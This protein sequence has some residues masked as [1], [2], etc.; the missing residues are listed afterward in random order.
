MK[1]QEGPFLVILCNVF[2]FCQFGP[3]CKHIH[4]WD[5]PRKNDNAETGK[6]G[7]TSVGGVTG[8]GR[9]RLMAKCVE[10]HRFMSAPAHNLLP[11]YP[12]ERGGDN[13]GEWAF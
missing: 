13:K 8:V 6:I 10:G 11:A 7:W 2:F 1:T 9:R 4:H 3:H 5:V 12:G